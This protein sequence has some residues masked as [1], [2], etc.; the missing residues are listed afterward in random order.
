MN[1][2]MIDL[3]TKYTAARMITRNGPPKYLV[4]ITRAGNT[5]C[6]DVEARDSAEAIEKAAELLEAERLLNAI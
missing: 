6:I 2:S 4:W 1:D 3:T 5:V